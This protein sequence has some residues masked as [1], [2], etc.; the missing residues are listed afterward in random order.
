MCPQ[1][2]PLLRMICPMPPMTSHRGDGAV[3]MAQAGVERLVRSWLGLIPRSR[4]VISDLNP[5]YRVGARRLASRVKKKDAVGP[6]TAD[7]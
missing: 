7:S 5:P 2:F 4:S 3:M 6:F 1:P